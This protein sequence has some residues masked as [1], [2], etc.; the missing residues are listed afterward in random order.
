[1]NRPY[2]AVA[3]SPKQRIVK[4]DKDI[5]TFE[6]LTKKFPECEPYKRTLMEITQLRAEL[7]SSIGTKKGGRK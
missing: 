3:L 5:K 2:K 7:A 1:M 4:L 6:A